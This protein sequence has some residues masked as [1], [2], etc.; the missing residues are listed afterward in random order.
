ASLDS[1]LSGESKADSVADRHPVPAFN[2]QNRN[3]R[4][5]VKKSHRRQRRT[6]RFLN[7][8][9]SADAGNVHQRRRAVPTSRIDNVV[10]PGSKLGSSTTASDFAIIDVRIICGAAATAACA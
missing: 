2:P 5:T 4:N 3:G 10:S 1:V 6:R 8:S 9:T 7:P